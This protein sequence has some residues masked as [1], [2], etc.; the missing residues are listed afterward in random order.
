MAIAFMPTYTQ[1]IYDVIVNHVE[2]EYTNLPDTH[3]KVS[4]GRG[5]LLQRAAHIIVNIA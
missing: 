4:Q 1:N 3:L 5:G 2:K